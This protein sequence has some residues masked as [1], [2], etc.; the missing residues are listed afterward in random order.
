MVSGK[1]SGVFHVF[2]LVDILLLRSGSLKSSGVYS[3]GGGGGV[4]PHFSLFFG[5][6]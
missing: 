5:Q 2:C 3:R 1:V 6:L 4:L